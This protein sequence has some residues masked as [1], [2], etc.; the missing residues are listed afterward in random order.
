MPSDRVFIRAGMPWRIVISIGT[1]RDT[2]APDSATIFRVASSMS[3]MWMSRLLRLKRP[4]LAS[5]ANTFC[6]DGTTYDASGKSRFR[7]ICAA[8]S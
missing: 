7:A 6:I 3:V 2:P 5:F 4:S 1:E 8:R